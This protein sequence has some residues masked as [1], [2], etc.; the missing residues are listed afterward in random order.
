MFAS[1]LQKGIFFLGGISVFLYIVC[2]DYYSYEFCLA[3][4]ILFLMQVCIFFRLKS[5]KSFFDFDTIFLLVFGISAYVYPVF[6]YNDSD[7]FVYFFN[8]HFNTDDI[9]RAVVISTIAASFYMLGGLSKNNI[10]KKK[11][12]TDSVLGMAKYIDTYFLVIIIVFLTIAFIACGGVAYYEAE[13]QKTGIVEPSGIIFQLQSLLQSFMIAVIGIEFYNVQNCGSRINRVFVLVCLLVSGLMLYSGKRSFAMQIMLPL[14]FLFTYKYVKITKIRFVFL[15]IVGFV[16]MWII[17]KTRSGIEIDEQT[18]MNLASIMSDI[19]IPARNNYLVFDVVEKY[20]YTLGYSMTGGIIG[21]IPSLERFL[22]FVGVDST[23]L[24][25]AT[26]FTS[27]TF[28]D[29]PPLGLG[30]MLQADVYLS[31]G[32]LGI[33]IFFF[34]LGR[35]VNIVFCNIRNQNYYSYIIYA[36]LMAHSIFWVRAE[37]TFPLRIIV[38]SLIIA[39]INRYFTLFHGKKNNVLYS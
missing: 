2:P 9:S 13:Y 11:G 3:S 29:S 4:F 16:F 18:T 25:S 6:L 28:G 33:I 24:G 32:I 21:V 1:F 20:G 5:K 37:A 15:A 39:Y 12:N 31:F 27:Y 35:S 30:T 38:W 7:P 34:F 14:S 10:R 17:Q 8:L 23:G 19:V 22:N 26:L 36:S